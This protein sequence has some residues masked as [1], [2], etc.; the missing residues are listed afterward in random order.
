MSVERYDE[1]PLPAELAAQDGLEI[2]RVGIVD[3]SLQTV[4]KRCFDEPADWGAA[5]AEILQ[6]AA[7]VYGK[8]TDI[9]PEDALTRMVDMFNRMV[10]QP[11]GGTATPVNEH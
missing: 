5:A 8:E 9:P 6:Y 2:L 4:L 1:I 10:T 3:G 11:R 7:E